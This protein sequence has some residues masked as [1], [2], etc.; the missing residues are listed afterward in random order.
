MQADIVKRVF[1]EFMEGRTCYRIA[2]KLNEEGIKIKSNRN[3]RPTTIRIM[4]DTENFTGLKSPLLEA[5]QLKVDI[6]FP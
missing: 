2:N 6:K 1:D 3:G 5:N 4:L